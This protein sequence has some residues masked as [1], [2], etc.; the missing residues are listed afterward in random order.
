MNEVKDMS[1]ILKL[2]R[3]DP[4][5]VVLVALLNSVSMAPVPSP[6]RL[7]IAVLTNTVT[8]FA[9]LSEY[10]RISELEEFQEFRE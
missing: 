6:G 7:L 1:V 2:R 10:V 4:I 8:F 9:A 5:V 3:L